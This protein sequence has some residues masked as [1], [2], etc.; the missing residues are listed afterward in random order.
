MLFISL[1]RI[2]FTFT[3]GI[4]ILSNSN[5]VYVGTLDQ[6]SYIQDVTIGL[7]ASEIIQIILIA[8]SLLYLPENFVRDYA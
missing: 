2:C 5:I 3:L 1:F 7:M 6:W 4:V 8:F